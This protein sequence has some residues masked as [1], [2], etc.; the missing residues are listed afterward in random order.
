MTGMARVVGTFPRMMGYHQAECISEWYLSAGRSA[1]QAGVVKASGK[2]GGI[3]QV[4]VWCT[5]RRPHHLAWTETRMSR[6]LLTLLCT[7]AAVA[8]LGGCGA[9]TPAGGAATPAGAGPAGAPPGGGPARPAGPPPRPPPP[10]G[11]GRAAG[12]PA[13]P[14]PGSPPRP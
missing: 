4:R 1:E 6:R 13:P 2:K 14:P 7:V 11:P 8:M 12:G 5:V 9:A 3:P 10:R